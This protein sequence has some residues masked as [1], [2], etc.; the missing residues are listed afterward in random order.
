MTTPHPCRLLLAGTLA[1]LTIAA[2]DAPDAAV[3]ADDEQGRV[4]NAGTSLAA[5]GTSSGTVAGTAGELESA[6]GDSPLGHTGTPAQPTSEGLF[7][8][9]SGVLGKRDRQMVGGAACEIT[10]TYP[11]YPPQIVIWEEPC[12]AVDARIMRQPQ[13]EEFNRWERIDEYGRKAIAERTGGD[14]LY[15]G[16]SFS[17]SV[18][19]M[20]YNQ[21]PFEIAV[22]D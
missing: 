8:A 15:V 3:A 4:A 16:G 18:F 14:V 21:L 22:A 2:C 13:L 1:C 7:A 5:P 19:P 9:N 10:F 12:K 11:D 20:D 17:A 6:Q